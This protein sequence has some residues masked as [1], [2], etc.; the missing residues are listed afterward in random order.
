[1][2]T[3]DPRVDA[4]IA[5]A[6]PFAQPVLKHLRATVHGACPDVEETIKWGMPSFTY[7]GIL[8]GMASFKAYCTFGFWKG[9]LI[10]DAQHRG[11]ERAMGDLGRITKMSDLPSKRVLANYVRQAMKL[12][13]D[14]VK[15][16][17]LVKR[18]QRAPKPPPRTPADLAAALKQNRQAL[19]TFEGFSPSHRREY[20]EWIVGAKTDETRT[21][22]LATAI[23]WMAEGKPQNWKYAR[24]KAK[25]TATA[26]RR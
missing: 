11:T 4:Y 20:I 24:A 1:M 3:K 22:R 26:K 16:P 9:E 14:G 10:V 18:A 2:G 7:H 15:A 21:R 19:A 23:A 17:W 5:K 12:N 25:A 8:C 6:A 13:E